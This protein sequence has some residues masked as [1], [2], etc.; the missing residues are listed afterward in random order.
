MSMGSSLMTEISFTP[1]D[2]I[3]FI[4]Q[5]MD[6]FPSNE[7]M[8]AV[9]GSTTCHNNSGQTIDW[10]VGAGNSSSS[11]GMLQPC[12]LIWAQLAIVLFGLSFI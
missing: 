9:T 7:T 4:N 3:G 11:A 5:A 10:R 12:W 2:I 6:M 8:Y 1:Q